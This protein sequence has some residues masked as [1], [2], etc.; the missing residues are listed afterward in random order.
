MAIDVD[1]IIDADPAS[2]LVAMPLEQL[3]V[4][5]LHREAP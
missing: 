4:E 5:V 1:V 2:A 3:L